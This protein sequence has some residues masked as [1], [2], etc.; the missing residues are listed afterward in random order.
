MSHHLQL[1]LYHRLLSGLL[2]KPGATGHTSIE[3][4]GKERRVQPLD[5]ADLWHRLSFNSQR[6]FSSTFIRDA[7]R[8]LERG[9]MGASGESDTAFECLDDLV[10]MWRKAVEDLDIDGVDDTLTLEYSLQTPDGAEDSKSGPASQTPI[11][12]PASDETTEGGASSQDSDVTLIGS[13]QGSD[14]TQVAD[15]DSEGTATSQTE[16]LPK[17]LLGVKKFQMDDQKL[18]A[19]LRSILRWWHGKRRPKGVPQELERRCE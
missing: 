11:T 12:P 14:A 10:R 19:H 15:E 8:L 6:P 13:S 3:A 2:A 18:D 1:M 9:K 7:R 5:F 16:S 4:N 17:G